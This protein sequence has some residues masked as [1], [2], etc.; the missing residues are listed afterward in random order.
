MQGQQ[1]RQVESHQRH[2]VGGQLMVQV[3]SILVVKREAEDRDGRLAQQLGCGGSNLIGRQ[4]ILLQ[5]SPAPWCSWSR[6]ASPHRPFF[7]PLR[8][9]WLLASCSVSAV[10]KVLQTGE[11][12]FGSSSDQIDSGLQ[13]EVWIIAPGQR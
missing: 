11:S 13:V 4:A 12:V 10:G 2:P 1:V 5:R 3:S 7:F 8:P 9:V 6:T